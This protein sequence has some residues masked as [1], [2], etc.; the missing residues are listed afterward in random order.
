[1]QEYVEPK[2]AAIIAAAIKAHPD[3]LAT[4]D[5]KHLLDPPEVAARSGLTILT[6]GDVL[7][8][9]RR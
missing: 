7:A 1:V 6:P 3:Y 2:D 8:R 4:L 5:R 9:I